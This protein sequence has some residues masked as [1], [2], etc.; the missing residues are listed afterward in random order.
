MTIHLRQPFTANP[1]PTTLRRRMDFHVALYSDDP[2]E[3][4]TFEYTSHRQDVFFEEGGGPLVREE[5]IDGD[6]D[7]PV[8][9]LHRIYI[10]KL[11]GTTPSEAPI[12]LVITGPG[13]ESYRQ[14]VVI[15]LK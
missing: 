5:E 14:K 8:E 11:P 9:V 2:P 4:A 7:S 13:G 10:D 6:A 12:S 15:E 1:S 3:T